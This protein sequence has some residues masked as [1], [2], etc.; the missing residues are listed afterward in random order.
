M[1]RHEVH[2]QHLLC[3][4]ISPCKHQGQPA[5]PA[6][7]S[8]VGR[9]PCH[10]FMMVA[11]F[12]Q[13]LRYVVGLDEGRCFTMEHFRDNKCSHRTASCMSCCLSVMDA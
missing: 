13:P 1:R 9:G 5:S 2:R 4:T 8:A 3:L 10:L 12:T 6:H 7:D 11:P